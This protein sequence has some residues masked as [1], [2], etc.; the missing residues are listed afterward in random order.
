MNRSSL[1]LV[2]ILAAA[3]GPLP[4]QPSVVGGASTAA[5]FQAAQTRRVDI[6]LIGDSTTTYRGTG[7]DHGWAMA[8]STRLGL[9]ATGIHTAGENSGL[10]GSV[11]YRSNT[12]FS[13]NNFTER[14]SYTGAPAH[15]NSRLSATFNPFT[16]LYTPAGQSVHSQMSN[17]LLIEQASPLNVNARLVFHY[18]YGTFSTASGGQFSPVVRLGSSPFTTLTPVNNVTT[19]GPGDLR[20][21][22]IELPAA[23]RNS[24]LEFRWNQAGVRQVIGPFFGLHMRVER[25]DITTGVS[26]HTLFYRGGWSMRDIAE[27]L[28]ASPDETLVEALA[29]MRRLQ[30][31]PQKL[32]IRISGGVNDRFEELVSRGP[33]AFLPGFSADAFQDNVFA[34]MQRVRTVWASQ[35]WDPNQLYFVLTCSVPVETPE[36]LQLIGYRNRLENIART[37]QRTSTVRMDVLTNE[38]E[39]TARN[40][41]ITPTDHFHLTQEAFEQLALRE[42]DA[43]LAV[44]CSTDLNS[45]G[46]IDGADVQAFFSL[47]ANSQEAGDFN[48]DGGIDGSD[49]EAFFLV[50]QTGDCS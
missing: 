46:G 37:T 25:P 40:W 13:N 17:G 39:L 43:L 12:L 22:S 2:L 28:Q 1:A 20:Y 35:E 9:Y 18:S 23:P 8:A 47:W 45:D 50:W 27:A 6:A 34:I 11:G 33:G 29:Q 38:A 5:F 19:F 31:A 42:I 44:T 30:P 15:L 7:W 14:F 26:L 36:D 21:A 16:Y 4:A 3:A 32:L 49:V 48:Q 10:G 24:A 41:Y